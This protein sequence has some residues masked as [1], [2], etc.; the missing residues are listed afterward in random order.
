MPEM[1]SGDEIA[2][3]EAE[4]A[5]DWRERYRLWVAEVRTGQR[6]LDWLLATRADWEA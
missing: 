3:R 4:A 1:R 6:A 5:E 2:A